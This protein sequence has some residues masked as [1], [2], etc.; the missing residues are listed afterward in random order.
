MG[1]P[2]ELASAAALLWLCN[3]GISVASPTRTTAFGPS[4]SDTGDAA[5][6][7]TPRI[8]SVVLANK[9]AAVGADEEIEQRARARRAVDQREWKVIRS[10]IRFETET[11]P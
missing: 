4:G 10:Q 8:M 9:A 2:T 3:D 11:R 6:I 1:I 5:N 7:S